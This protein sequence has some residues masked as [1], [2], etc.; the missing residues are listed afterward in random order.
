MCSAGVKTR[1]FLKLK[2][3]LEPFGITRYY[4]DGWGGLRASSRRGSNTRLAGKHAKDRE[5]AHP[6]PDANQAL[7]APYDLLFQKRTDA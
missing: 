7:G 6:A 3:L 5:Q 1:F 4:T 2:A